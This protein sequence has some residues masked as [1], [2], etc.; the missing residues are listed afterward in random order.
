MKAIHNRI[1]MGFR[2][3]FVVNILIYRNN[4]SNSQ[5]LTVKFNH[6]KSCQSSPMIPFPA[7]VP[8]VN[9]P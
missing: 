9:D 6:K 7:N 2:H 3:M 5:L 8:V 4:E 1:V